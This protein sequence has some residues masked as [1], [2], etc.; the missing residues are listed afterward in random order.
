MTGGE[1]AGGR[2]A[3][4]GTGWPHR[5][6]WPAPPAAGAG[7]GRRRRAT[8]AAGAGAGGWAGGGAGAALA[9]RAPP[10]RPTDPGSGRGRRGR[11][12][13]IGRGPAGVGPGMLDGA[14]G[15]GSLPGGVW[16]P[17]GMA[18][19][20]RNRGG[21]ENAR[22]QHAS[23]MRAAAPERWR[24]GARTPP[25]GRKAQA[26]RPAWPVRGPQAG[27]C[28]GTRNASDQFTGSQTLEARRRP[29]AAA[30]PSAS[31]DPVGQGAGVHVDLELAALEVAADQLL[32]ERILDVALDGA[33]QRTRP[34]RAVLAGQVDDPVDG[35]GASAG[36]S[37]A[38]RPGW[39]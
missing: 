16:A 4:G 7:S 23:V 6:G 26:Y 39:R 11:V 28:L 19:H 38:D 12:R 9:G 36:S 15:G 21:Q 3:G 14:A 34:V 13:R 37:G 5:V 1:P 30:D 25:S 35:L 32:G 22:T 29:G 20:G 24:H 2:R 18:S 17:A 27:Q 10:G 8:P 31:S 33:A